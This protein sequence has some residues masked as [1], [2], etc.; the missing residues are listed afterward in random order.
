MN[1]FCQ[2]ESYANFPGTIWRRNS[3]SIS[4]PLETQ[5][6]IENTKESASGTSLLSTQWWVVSICLIRLRR[7]F[8]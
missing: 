6:P 7:L 5:E 1:A 2:K 3:E 8:N 4:G